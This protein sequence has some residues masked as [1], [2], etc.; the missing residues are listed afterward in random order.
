M[1]EQPT[2]PEFQLIARLADLLGDPATPG[3]IGIGDDCAGI[4]RGDGYLLMACD[5]AMDGRHFQRGR[6]P[7][8][9]VGWK[10]ATANVSDVVACGGL[11][12][13]A[14][15]SLGVPDGMP[16]EELDD[17]YK[18]LREAAQAYGFQIVGGNVTGARDLLVDVFILGETRRFLPR[19]GAQPGDLVAVSGTL[20]DS[21]AGLTLLRAQGAGDHPLIR[22]HLRPRARTELV[23][24]LQAVAHAAIDISDGLAAEA[25]HVAGASGV[26]LALDAA[27]IPLSPEL[28]DFAAG[29]GEQPLDWALNSGEEYQ[30]L[31]TLDPADRERLAGHDVTVIG[32]VEAGSGVTLSGKP[33]PAGGWDHL[34]PHP[35]AP[36]E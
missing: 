23:P 7:M 33:L 18:G 21:A 11:P 25:H 9:D 1:A 29:R 26:G 30:I 35:A 6:A 28:R 24:L 13:F 5:I 22:R 14:L 19:S 3:V 20:G 17:L 27:A 8:T 4:P 12:T 34:G 2:S 31:F 16:Q 15:V 32:T 36:R 10:V